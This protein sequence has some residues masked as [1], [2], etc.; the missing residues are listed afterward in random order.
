MKKILII[1]DELAYVSLL[2]DTLAKT[3]QVI[4]AKNGKEGLEYAI[5][6]HPNLMLLDI[7]MPVMDGM[8]MLGKLRKDAWGKT[9]KVI[10]LTNL[11]PS[12]SVLGQVVKDLPTYY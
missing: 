1:E 11:E 4:V 10:L 5:K 12:D 3:Y 7:K 8:T 9:A 2:R 6:E